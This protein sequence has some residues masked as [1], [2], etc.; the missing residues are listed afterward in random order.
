M[1]HAWVLREINT[2]LLVEHQLGDFGTDRV[3]R[4]RMYGL[5]SLVQGQVQSR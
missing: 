2:E 1:Q 5:D 4:L 3:L